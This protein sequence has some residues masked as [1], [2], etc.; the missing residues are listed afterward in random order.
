[1]V[2]QSSPGLGFVAGDCG[3]SGQSLVGG[4]EEGDTVDFIKDPSDG[5]ISQAGTLVLRAK[6]A[7]PCQIVFV[8]PGSLRIRSMMW[9]LRF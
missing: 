3:I 5:G 8:S 7:N 2:P 1:M 6:L 9:V 4:D